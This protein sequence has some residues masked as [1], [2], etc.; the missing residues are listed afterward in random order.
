MSGCKQRIAHAASR[1]I[2]NGDSIFVGSGSTTAYLPRYLTRYRDLTVVTNALNIAT[3]LSRADNLTV[4]VIGGMLRASELSLVGHIAELGLAEVRVDKVF[5]GMAAVCLKAGLTNDYLPEV[6]T[7][8][9]LFE[10]YSERVLLADH[11]KFGKVRSAYVGPVEGVHTLVTDEQTDK[12]VIEDL[13]GLGITVLV[14]D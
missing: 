5:I 14:A 1:L 8:R 13:R 4:V 3:D 9:K 10:M 7:D 12:R 11:T 6:R 2:D